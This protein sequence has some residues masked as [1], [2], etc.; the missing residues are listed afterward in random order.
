[1]TGESKVR[2][3]KTKPP[4][5]AIKQHKSNNQPQFEQS[6]SRHSLGLLELHN[7]LIAKITWQARKV[8]FTAANSSIS[9]KGSASDC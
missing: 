7:S 1:M 5:R 4:L 9:T 8:G 3:E 2:G 6:Q